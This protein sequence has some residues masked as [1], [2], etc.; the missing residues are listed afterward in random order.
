MATHPAQPSAPPPPPLPPEAQYD[1]LSGVYGF[2]RRHQKKL[3]YTAG[4]FTLL[5]FSIT[6]PVLDT[7]RGLTGGKD[8]GTT[9]MV[10]GKRVELEASDYDFG[11]RIAKNLGGAIPRGV[12][13]PVAS[14]DDAAN[15]RAEVLAVLRRAAILEG[16]EP[17]M[18]EVDKAIEVLREQFS[19][20]S[21]TRLATQI[22][23]KSLADYREVMAEAMRIGTYVQL[24]SLAVDS[25]EASVLQRVIGKREKIT[26]KVATFDEKKLEEDLKK[27]TIAEEDLRK[28]MEAKDE[29]EKGRIGIYDLPRAELRFGALLLAEGQFDPAQWQ[30]GHLK[31]FTATDDMLQGIYEQ[32]K[33]DR[34]KLE[35]GG[36][37]PFDDAAVKTELTRLVQAEQVMNKLLAEL[38]TKKEDALRPQNTVLEEA[39]AD[40]TGAETTKLDLEA[41]RDAKKRDLTAKEE[42][43]AKAPTDES[44][45]QAVD[46]LQKAMK[47][48]EDQIFAHDPVLTAKKKVVTD[49]EEAL[50]VAGTTFDFAAAFGELTKDKSGFVV[51]AMTGRKNSDELKDLDAA[52][53]ELG[54]GTWK[55]ASQATGLAN[56]GDLGF[57]P[58]RTSKAIIIFQ[59]TDL[60]PK[61]LKSPEAIKPL[62]E[63]AYWTEQAK[64]QGEEKKK[65]MEDALLRLAK[66]K[67]ADK[68]AEIEGK[69]QARIDEK[70]AAWETEL[71]A[72]KVE[73]EKLLAQKN[74]G[75]QAR[76][77]W[78]KKLESVT[79]QLAAKAQQVTDQTASMQKLIDIEL[80]DEA[81][82]LHKDVLDAAAAETG[83]T[84][85]D[86]GPY[87]RDLQTREPR[88]DKRYDPT[89]VFLWRGHSKLKEGESTGLVQDFT[90]RRYLAAVCTKVEPLTA[91]DVSR[92][93][94][95]SLRTGDGNASFATQQAY[96]SFMTAFAREAVEKR[97]QL[98]RPVAEQR[99]DKAST[100]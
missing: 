57:A 5:T 40:A 49:A 100:K 23:F 39:R 17:S 78:Q 4:L 52:G 25:S 62:A 47:S 51:K 79:Q 10:A 31:D 66:A 86:V 89:V 61:P 18:A 1:E 68:V 43:L 50:K 13:P 58:A 73:A 16:F 81:K 35:A 38:K 30:D 22:G 48:F 60:E 44:L 8:P 75:N 2:F 94:F 76:A 55:Q 36:H 33:E 41:Q 92:R 24:Q 19:A 93:D 3:L 72:Q 59:A 37:K 96:N 95:E 26:M 77:S 29:R 80:A 99:V 91:A 88:F 85:A 46:E 90:S 69:K 45:K 65:A 70:V 87:M 21:P 6:G 54:L 83:F 74:L 98:Q 56:K 11:N 42:E 71:Q 64:K 63:G 27:G 7:I 53:L 84:V 97:Y 12:L 14:G 32:E 28:W 20:T 9:I 34:F 67:M 15:D 82:K